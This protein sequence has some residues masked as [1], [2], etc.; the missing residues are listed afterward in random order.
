[1]PSDNISETAAITTFIPHLLTTKQVLEVLQFKKSTFHSKVRKHPDFPK[2]IF[3]GG[4]MV[5]YVETE[6]LEFKVKFVAN[7]RLTW[8]VN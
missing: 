6:I 2:P 5:R 8:P 1:M 4:R 7:R 3:C